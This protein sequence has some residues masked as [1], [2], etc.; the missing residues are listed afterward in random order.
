[1]R[2]LS[3]V[4]SGMHSVQPVATSTVVNVWMNGPL[5]WLLGSKNKI[6]IRSIKLTLR[7]VCLFKIRDW[8]SH[9]RTAS[10]FSQ[11]SARSVPKPSRLNSTRN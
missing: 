4:T 1:M 6:D 8:A 7:L 11:S 3:R 9:E 2:P 10:S 5:C